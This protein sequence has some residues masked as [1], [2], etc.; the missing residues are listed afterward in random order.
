MNGDLET[1]DIVRADVAYS[2]GPG[3][4]V[5][6]LEDAAGVDIWDLDAIITSEEVLESV[7]GEVDIDSM[8]AWW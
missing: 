8:A 7:C 6:K 5:R 4:T 2:L 1:A 3:T